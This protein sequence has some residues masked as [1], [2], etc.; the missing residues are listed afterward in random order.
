MQIAFVPA[1]AAVA[2]AGCAGSRP[3]PD[4]RDPA[5]VKDSPVVLRVCYVD[6][7]GA[8]LAVGDQVVLT[9][10]NFGRLRI[11]HIPGPENQSGQ[12]NGGEPAKVKATV[13]VERSAPRGNKVNTRKFVP[14]GRFH[15]RLGDAG[16]HAPFDFQQSKVVAVPR[17]DK[18][19][20]CN[21]EI[22]DD[23]VLVRGVEDQGR[24][25][26]TAHLR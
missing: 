17:V 15:V 8:H 19:P 10:S 26:G 14:V 12:W 23:E 3:L 9:T 25:G 1:L 5:P 20:D 7:D 22:G 6:G 16:A 18:Y 21:A 2:L 13:L 24:H 4:P 11:R